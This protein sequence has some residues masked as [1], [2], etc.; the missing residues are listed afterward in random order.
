VRYLGVDICKV[1][2]EMRATECGYAPALELGAVLRASLGDG[3]EQG[4]P[5]D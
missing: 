2:P 1:V 4:N 5:W 3:R